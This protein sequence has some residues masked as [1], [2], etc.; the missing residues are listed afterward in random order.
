MITQT[1]NRIKL[2]VSKIEAFNS[3]TAIAKIL[4][5]YAEADKRDILA[6]AEQVLKT[7]SHLGDER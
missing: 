4:L 1:K 2:P 3:A 7:F 5:P 6:K